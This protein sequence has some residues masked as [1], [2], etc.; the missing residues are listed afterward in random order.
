MANLVIHVDGANAAGPGLTSVS[1]TVSWVDA[2]GFNRSIGGD[3]TV[4]ATASAE[5]I[6]EALRVFSI[7]LAAAAPHG[8][9]SAAGDVVRIF[10]G[11]VPNIS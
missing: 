1:I 5:D 2:E 4:A 10:G 7:E 3:A 11:A 9:T 6:N 8:V